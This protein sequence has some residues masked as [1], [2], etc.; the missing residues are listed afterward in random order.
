MKMILRLLNSKWTKIWFALSAAAFAALQISR[1]NIFGMVLNIPIAFVLA[2]FLEF[3]YKILDKLFEFKSKKYM[4]ISLPI[5]IY[6]VIEIVLAFYSLWIWLFFI[7]ENSIAVEIRSLFSE[8]FLV[9]GFFIFSAALG[10]TALFFVF[11]LIYAVVSRFRIIAD[12]AKI[13]FI[14]TDMSERIYFAATVLIFGVSAIMLYNLSPVFWGDQSLH[15]GY[16]DFIFGFDIGYVFHHDAQFYFPSATFRRLFYPLVNFPLALIARALGRILFFI[17]YSFV[18]FVNL[19]HIGLI[20]VGGILLAR[21][22]ICSKASSKTKRVSKICFLLLYTVSF[23]FLVFSISC[24]RFVLPTFCI[25]LLVYIYIHAPKLKS[26]AALAAAGT[27]T[28]S[29]VTFPFIAYDRNIKTMLLNLVK[30]IVAFVVICIF[31]GVLP[32][33]VNPIQNLFADLESFGSGGIS[34]NQKALQFLNFISSCFVSPETELVHRIDTSDNAPGFEYVVYTVA[35]PKTV[36]WFGI[37]MITLS[38]AGFIANRKLRFAQMSFSWALFAVFTLFVVGWQAKHNES[39]LSGFYFG[40]AFFALVFMLFEKL[41]AKLNALKYI[42]YSVA[43]VVMTAININGIIGLV[44]YT[45]QY[46]PAR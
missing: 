37:V 12:N 7:A 6:A 14:G 13:I 19:L 31:C 34:I 42:L 15:S 36:N 22:C 16:H 17:P 38:A 32:K 25:I 26:L 23:P 21:M 39:F 8:Q 24:E 30:L 33:L 9:V 45:I 20:T 11:A 10:T 41:P 4:L 29:V 27:L 35:L 43:F 5:A 3:K 40:W 44:N 28:T 2:L 18:Y 46:Y 1:G